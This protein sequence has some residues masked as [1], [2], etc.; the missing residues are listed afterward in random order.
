[1]NTRTTAIDKIALQSEAEGH[2]WPGSNSDPSLITDGQVLD[3]LVL[4]GGAIPGISYIGVIKELSRRHMLAQFQTFA[5]T[6]VG[7]LV[8]CMLACRATS[9]FIEDAF[10][11]INLR[12]LL[13][14]TY[15][16]I[17]TLYRLLMRNGL[18]SGDKLLGWVGQQ[19]QHLTGKADITFAEAYARFNT[20]L[21]VVAT[22]LDKQQPVYFTHQ[23][24]PDLMIRQAVRMSCSIPW[25]FTAVSHDGRTMV[26][27][28]LTDNFPWRGILQYGPRRKSASA[29]GLLSKLAAPTVA[30]AV[31]TAKPDSALVVSEL[32]DLVIDI[33]P[34]DF[35]AGDLRNALGVKLLTSLYH[36]PL[37]S[38]AHW[39][40]TFAV[41][42]LE[43]LYNRAM[44]LTFH[45]GEEFSTRTIIVQTGNVSILDFG[46]T[47]TGKQRLIDTGQESTA[48]YL[49]GQQK[50][51][52]I[53]QLKRTRAALA[54][55]S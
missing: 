12:S 14:Y 10:K 30:A 27:G 1:M 29:I 49:D 21:V 3:A 26:D 36:K 16:P 20:T 53:K 7:S 28:G 47:A 4:E 2:K 51:G 41:S 45:S 6:S 37:F 11:E 17:T 24:T 18:C 54:P 25:V 32:T 5:G 46:I 23:T 8:V 42:L 39:P 15:N 19:L 44:A 50:P 38:S 9:Q 55:Y 33:E 52:A 22:D 13:D 48:A 43:T 34:V 31:A 35:Y 40:V